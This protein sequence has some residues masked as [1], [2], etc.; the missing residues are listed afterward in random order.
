MAKRSELGEREEVKAGEDSPQKRVERRMRRCR[1][2]G[3]CFDCSAGKE[4]AIFR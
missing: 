3:R 2:R 1:L 4:G